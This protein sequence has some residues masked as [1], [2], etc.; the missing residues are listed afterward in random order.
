MK[1][2]R[3]LIIGSGFGGQAAAVNLRNRGIQ[4]FLILE[5]RSY[6]GGAWCQNTYPGAQVDVQSPLYSF[7][8][9][10][11]PW[12]RMFAEQAELQKYTNYVIDKHRLRNKTE[13]NTNVER[14]QPIIIGTIYNHQKFWPQIIWPKRIKTIGM[15]R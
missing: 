3:V 8:F 13:L 14:V 4:D 6:M 2:F 7:S 1:K 15:K 5:R 10:P 11:Y 12:S 9:E